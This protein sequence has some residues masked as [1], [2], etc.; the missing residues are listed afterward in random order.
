MDTVREVLLATDF[1]ECAEAAA[2]I[3]RDYARRFGARLHVLHVLWGDAVK[4][5]MLEKLGEELRATVPVVT[6]VASGNAASEIVKYAARHRIDL[7]VVGTHGRTGATRVLLGSVAERVVRLAP[8]PVLT[9]PRVPAATSEAEYREPLERRRCLVC[10]RQSDDLVCE[11]C[12]A[13]V[14]GEALDHK[15]REERPG[16]G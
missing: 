1:S 6:A 8:C 15:R 14:R 5:P 7:I 13:H 2:V 10:A 11:P 4:S 9:V 3:A 16:R 12:R